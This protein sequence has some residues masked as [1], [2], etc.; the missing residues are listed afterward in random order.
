MATTQNHYAYYAY[1]IYTESGSDFAVGT[2][3]SVMMIY[4]L[5]AGDTIYSDSGRPPVLGDKS[6]TTLTQMYEKGGQFWYLRVDWDDATLSGVNAIYVRID[7]DVIH[8]GSTLHPACKQIAL[9]ANRHDGYKNDMRNVLVGDLDVASNQ[10]TITDEAGLPVVVY[11]LKDTNGD[12]TST[13]PAS[14]ERVAIT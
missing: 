7:P 14:R 1:Y 3:S 4:D 12:P 11:D 5:D 6:S 9:I 10:M 13:A 8:A 2:T